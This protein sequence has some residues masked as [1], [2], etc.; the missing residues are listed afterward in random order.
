MTDRSAHRRAQTRKTD[1]AETVTS[2]L[3]ERVDPRQGD[4]FDDRFRPDL[5]Q[6]ARVERWYAMSYKFDPYWPYSDVWYGIGT[7]DDAEEYFR[8]EFG[9]AW[10]LTVADF[11]G[12][13]EESVN[14][15]RD[16][17]VNFARELRD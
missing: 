8:R 2:R 7:Q 14:H 6:A 16:C 9:E 11:T 5:A 17:G 1:L 4:L 3:P 15:I 10:T 13:D 12:M